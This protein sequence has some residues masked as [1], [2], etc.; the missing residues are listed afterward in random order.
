MT[1]VTLAM[2][3]PMNTMIILFIL[4]LMFGAKKLPELARGLGQAMKEFSKAKN[5]IH[6]E[7][8]KDPPQT[9]QVVQP[10]QPPQIAPPVAQTQQPAGTQPQTTAAT[11]PEAAPAPAPEPP[12]KTA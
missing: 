4:L 8:M 10:L 5:D 3:T 12:V 1:T 2:L 6:D 11:T 9:S 7:I